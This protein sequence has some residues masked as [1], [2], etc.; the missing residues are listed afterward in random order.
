[1]NM[2]VF[3]LG[4]VN[5]LFLFLLASVEVSGLVDVDVLGEF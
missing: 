3:L 2:F 4:G 1:V 5:F